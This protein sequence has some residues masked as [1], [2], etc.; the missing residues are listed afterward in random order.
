MNDSQ[1]YISTTRTGLKYGF[2][3]AVA[4]LVVGIAF[5]L[6]FRAAGESGMNIFILCI[7][8]AYGMLEFRRAQGDHATYLQCFNLG[9]IV[10]VISGLFLGVLSSISAYLLSPSD[11]GKIKA[12]YLDQFEIQRYSEKE[13][14]SMKPILDFMFSPTGAFLGTVIVWCFLGLIVTAVSS[15]FMRRN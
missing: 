14:E 2:Y 10:S 1:P 3:T 7:G 9:M 15:L 11:L 5:S 8:I 4:C 13:I 6:L 12:M